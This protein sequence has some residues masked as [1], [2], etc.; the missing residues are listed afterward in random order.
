MLCISFQP[1]DRSP[2]EL[3]DITPHRDFFSHLPAL[4]LA[5]LAPQSL[6]HLKGKVQGDEVG[7][8][9][10]QLHLTVS[11]LGEEE[12]KELCGV[13]HVAAQKSGLR[14]A[15]DLLQGFD[16]AVGTL[17]VAPPLT[18]EDVHQGFQ[19]IRI[20]NKEG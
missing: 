3:V 17:D 13:L 10:S 7:L 15:H 8:Q 16:G 12:P 5:A 4:I 9:D 19:N 1:R 6:L 18:L 11:D 2:V 14:P 20:L